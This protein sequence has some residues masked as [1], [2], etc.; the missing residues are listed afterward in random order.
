[1]N[2]MGFESVT[3]KNFVYKTFPKEA[4]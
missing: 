3:F 2:A 4:A 1:M